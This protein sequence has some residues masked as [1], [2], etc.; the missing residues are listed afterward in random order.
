[1]TLDL[2]NVWKSYQAKDGAKRVLRGLDLSVG[3]QELVSL[4]GR[5]GCGKSTLLNCASGLVAPDTGTVTLDGAPVAGPGS[6][7]AMAF[8]RQA[9]LPLL[10]LMDNVRIAARA[11]RPRRGVKN[12]ELAQRCLVALGLWEYRDAR[13][14]QLSGP[15]LQ[16]AELARTLALEPRA[17]LL[18][19]PFAA[20]DGLIG[21]SLRSHLLE[22][23]RGPSDTEI[24]LLVTSDVDE[25]VRL[26]DRVVVMG[27]APGPSVV[28]TVA[29]DVPADRRSAADHPGL[30][31]ARDQVQA[32]LTRHDPGSA[33]VA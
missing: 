32:I 11:V 7:R 26:S 17:L 15:M 6:D 24:V 28:G 33:L 18:D 20:L 1:L 25:A 2:T 16:R 5:A 29:V 8:Q 31:A 10:S 9:L 19:D 30:A 3:P 21:A 12:D 23:W 22:L 4:V 13:P 27:H 14:S